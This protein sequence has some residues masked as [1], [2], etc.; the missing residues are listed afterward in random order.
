MIKII[1][2]AILMLGSGVA[3]S[4]DANLIDRTEFDPSI[5]LLLG[6]QHGT[7]VNYGFG[8]IDS[9]DEK[10]RSTLSIAVK[11]SLKTQINL[12]SSNVY[13]GVSIVAA[14]TSAS[15]TS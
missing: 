11:P 2:I 12:S 4:Y 8:A 6:L 10:S 15:T 9:K 7:G 14:T 3:S 1:F 5:K 13:S